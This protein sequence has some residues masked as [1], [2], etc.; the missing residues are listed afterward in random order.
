MGPINPSET[1]GELG[2]AAF[3]PKMEGVRL[4]FST[5][6]IRPVTAVSAGPSPHTPGHVQPLQAAGGGGV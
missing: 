6:R 4:R 2:P 3:H 5:N 1:S